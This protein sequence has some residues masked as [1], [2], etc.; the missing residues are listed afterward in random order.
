MVCRGGKAS[1]RP[2]A[3]FTAVSPAGPVFFLNTGATATASSEEGT[4][5]KF[6]SYT[7]VAEEVSVAWLLRVAMSQDELPENRRVLIV[8][9]NPDI[10]ADYRRV[11]D[12]APSVDPLA[13]TEAAL[14][15][16][17]AATT[18]PCVS[19]ELTHAH[20]GEEGYELAGRNLDLRPFALAFVDMRMPPGWDGLE[21]IK[22]LWQLDPRLQIVLCTAY[23]GY[24]WKEI[25][26]ALVPGDRL[27]ILKNRSTRLRFASLP[28]AW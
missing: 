19:F 23:S 10:H 5:I 12:D 28:P 11:L 14:F 27:V 9:D 15:G 26:D 24:S 4:G 13:V 20:Q 6:R 3:F 7:T 1:S 2:L 17:T 21:T 8:D 22:R 18:R 16:E 25:C